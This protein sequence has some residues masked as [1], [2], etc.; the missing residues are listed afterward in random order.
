MALDAI[1][2][3]AL[4]IQAAG[5]IDAKISVRW[6]SEMKRRKRCRHCKSREASR[7]RGL[8]STC[9]YAPCVRDL[10]PAHPKFSRRPIGI[11]GETLP[12]PAIAVPGTETKIAILEARAHGN[13]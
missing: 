5:R 13:L 4:R 9:Y 11:D 6:E 3:S 7:S 10:Y 2:M 1:E 12:S 8:C